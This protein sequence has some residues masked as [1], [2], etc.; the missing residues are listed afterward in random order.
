M[1]QASSMRMLVIDDDPGLVYALT[2][3]LSWDGYLVH[4]ARNG[5]EALALLHDY[6]Y[7]LILW[8]LRLSGCDERDFY[9]LLRQYPFLHPR[10]IFLT[11][12]PLR[13]ESMTFLEQCG[14]PWVSKPCPAAAVRSAIAQ[15]RQHAEP[16]S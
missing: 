1:V 13:R 14:Q 5:Y 10:V 12:D 7:D 11:G 15:V 16:C 3:L 6:H 8:D 9:V 4:T 2:R